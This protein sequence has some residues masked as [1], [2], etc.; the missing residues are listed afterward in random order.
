M[1]FGQVVSELDYIGRK[2][3]QGVIDEDGRFAEIEIECGEQSEDVRRRTACG[4]RGGFGCKA[5]ADGGGREGGG[6][7]DRAGRRGARVVV[8]EDGEEDRRGEARRGVVVRRESE[9]T[10]RSKEHL[11]PR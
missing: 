6:G 10:T 1:G 11:V 8:D 7:G 9:W 4:G 5:R 2:V 3:W